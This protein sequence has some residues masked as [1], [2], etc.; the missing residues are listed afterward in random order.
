MSTVLVILLP[1][2]TLAGMFCWAVRIPAVTADSAI[3]MK[4]KAIKG[5]R[6]VFLSF[7]CFQG[8]GV[9]RLIKRYIL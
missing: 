7:I 2:F 3:A 5:I 9:S 6:A 8:Y 4:T 1:T